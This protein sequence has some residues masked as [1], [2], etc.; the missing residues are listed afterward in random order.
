MDASAL[1]GS[2]NAV[3]P[4]VE[5]AEVAAPDRPTILVPR[6]HLVETGRV[7]RDS[8]G[9]AFEVLTE[10]T[11]GDW[12]PAEPRFQVVYHLLSPER[13]LLLRLLVRLASDD[14]HVP[15]LAGVWP[16]ASWLEREVWDLFGV[17]FEGHPDLR[18]LLMPEDWEGHPLRKDYPVQIKMKPKV[19]EPLQMSEQEFK[20][21]IIADRRVR[22]G[23]AEQAKN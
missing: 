15:T 23:D 4:G 14:P 17:V 22:G 6:E 1:V 5:L 18:R 9:L 3:L 8:P 12:W 13:G 2:L 20:D 11:A 21:K 10:I 7:L 19:Y 16:S